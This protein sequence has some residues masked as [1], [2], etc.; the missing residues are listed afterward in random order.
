MA[1]TLRRKTRLLLRGMRLMNN[2]FPRSSR[3]FLAK[4]E[5]HVRAGGFYPKRARRVLKRIHTQMLK[6][7]GRRGYY[8]T[9]GVS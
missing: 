6:N 8:S 7:V 1:Q 5:R 3:K 2:A 9:P 4:N